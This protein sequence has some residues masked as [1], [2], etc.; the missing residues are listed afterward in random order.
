MAVA[1][2]QAERLIHGRVNTTHLAVAGG[3]DS[4]AQA[5]E[6]ACRGLGILLGGVA[7]AVGLRDDDRERVR[8]DVVHLARDPGPL[9]RRRQLGL[10]VALDLEALGPVAQ[11]GDRLAPRSSHQIP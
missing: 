2:S 3:A 9:G 1:D 10:V 5:A 11:R 4:L 7:T 6:R 8:D